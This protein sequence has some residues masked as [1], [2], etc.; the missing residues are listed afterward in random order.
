MA[1]C[2]SIYVVTYQDSDSAPVDQNLLV[3]KSKVAPKEMSIPRLE[4][5]AYLGETAK[6]REQDIGVPP[7][8]GLSHLGG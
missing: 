7:Y 2:A 4:T 8:H 1:V 6:Q 3:A 5:S